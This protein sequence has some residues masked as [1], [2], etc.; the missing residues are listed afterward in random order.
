MKSLTKRKRSKPTVDRSTA[1]K[2]IDKKKEAVSLT[3]DGVGGVH[4]DLVLGGISDEPLGISEGDVGGGGTVSL[5]VGYD[6][7][8]VVL[9]D[10]DAGVGGAEIYS[11]GGPFSLSGHPRSLVGIRKI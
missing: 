1:C 4:G 2:R 10:A 8:A 3:K 7:D 6:L 9:P 5:V 11:N